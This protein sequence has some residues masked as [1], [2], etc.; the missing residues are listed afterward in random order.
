M[1]IIRGIFLI[2]LSIYSLKYFSLGVLDY[3]SMDFLHQINLGFHEWGHFIMIPFWD[4]LHILGGSL[5]QCLTP[6]IFALYFYFKENA[7]FSTAMCLWWMG[8]NFTD[9]A[10][11]IADARTRS[12]PLIGD[13]WPESHDW[14]NLLSM[15]DMLQYDDAIALI[16]HY[17]G[18]MIM[19]WAIIWGIKIIVKEHIEW[20]T[21]RSI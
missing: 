20:I 14:Y 15:M 18:M 12:L 17:T 13:M 5:F 6:M 3:E 2:L 21:R 16:S 4:F 1:L 8:E 11:Y 9:V 10:I 19:F 7:R